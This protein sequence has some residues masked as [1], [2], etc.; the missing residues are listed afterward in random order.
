MAATRAAVAALLM[1]LVVAILAGCGTTA[2]R[3]PEP[4]PDTQA[5]PPAAVEPASV[6]VPRLGISSS[7]VPL[8]LN[9]DGTI[10]VPSLDE[11]L[12]ASW[13]SEGPAPGEV[14]PAV[15]LGHV[16]AH[17]EPGIFHRLREAAEGDEITIGRA[18]GSALRFVV[19]RVAQVAKAEFPTAEV[20]GPTAEPEL[21]L[22]TC[23]GSFDRS[24]G[25][26]RDNVIVFARLA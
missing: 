10:A 7:L 19:T 9:P 26:Y 5:A 13:Y 3:A 16:D 11:P 20:Y 8:G 1:L 24:A 25:H 22:I 23:G 12:Q 18:D 4:V 14:G 6:E 2:G 15:V 21:R 17:G